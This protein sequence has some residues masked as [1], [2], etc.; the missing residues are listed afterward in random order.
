MSWS[1]SSL[2]LTLTFHSYR[3][4]DVTAKVVES[5]K[6]VDVRM[7]P[8]ADSS[9]ATAALCVI[10]WLDVDANRLEILSS[11]DFTC[12]D[13][14]EI[15]Q[16]FGTARRESADTV[17]TLAEFSVLKQSPFPIS[18]SPSGWRQIMFI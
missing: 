5:E 12:L 15:V 3:S 18:M 11:N 4:N 8:S 2:N 17:K 13:P 10:I 16:A 14:I 1:L 6:I 9:V 7:Y